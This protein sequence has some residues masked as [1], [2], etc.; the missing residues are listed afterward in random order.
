M[1]WFRPR[2]KETPISVTLSLEASWKIREEMALWKERG[3]PRSA[4]QVIEDLI[5]KHLR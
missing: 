1:T 5:N 4:A 3:H 2:P